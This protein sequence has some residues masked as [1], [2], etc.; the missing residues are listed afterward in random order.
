MS[1]HME[2]FAMLSVIR[3]H[4]RGLWLLLRAGLISTG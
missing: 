2:L 3:E 4:R 1:L